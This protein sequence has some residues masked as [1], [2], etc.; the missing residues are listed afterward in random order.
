MTNPMME[1]KGLAIE[2]LVRQAGCGDRQA[3]ADLCHAVGKKVLFS[4]MR[5]MPRSQDA[6]DVAQEVLRR[7]CGNIHTL[8]DPRAF[9]VWLNRIVLNE[10]REHARANAKQPSFLYLGNR[11]G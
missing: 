9:Y 1:D 3:L 5:L 6:E 4:V 8:K 10:V 2:K 7:L 11:R